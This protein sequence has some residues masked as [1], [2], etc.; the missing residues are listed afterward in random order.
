[1]ASRELERRIERLE[2]RSVAGIVVGLFHLPGTVAGDERVRAE[3]RRFE[4]EHDRRV[5]VVVI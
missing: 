3:L 4:A 5:A 2:Q 1:M